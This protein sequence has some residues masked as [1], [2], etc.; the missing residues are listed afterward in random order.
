[1]SKEYNGYLIV[2]DMCNTRS[3]KSIGSGALPVKLRGRFTKTVE[4]EQAIDFY[5]SSKEGAKRVKATTNS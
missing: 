4:A 2:P 1:M 5:L 3:I